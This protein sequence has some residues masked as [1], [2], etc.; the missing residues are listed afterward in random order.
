MSF[1]RSFFNILTR[2]IFVFLV[3]IIISIV[4][5]REL[6]PTMLGIWI[7]ISIL[8]QYLDYF[9]RFKFDVASINIIGE[10]RTNPSEVLFSNNLLTLLIAIIILPSFF[11]AYKFSFFSF[12]GLDEYKTAISFMII[13]ILI[14][15]LF[16]NY[17]YFL[18]AIQRSDIYANAISSQALLN[19]IF[20]V[21]FIY[22][23]NLGLEGIVFARLISCF[24]LLTYVFFFVHYQEDIR[25]FGQLPSWRYLKTLFFRS[26][27]FYFSGI[28][29]NILDTSFKALGSVLIS[30]QNLAFFSQAESFNKLIT[31]ASESLATIL[32]PTISNSQ[33]N[34]EKAKL[35]T[36]TTFKYLLIFQSFV[37]ALIYWIAEDIFI[38]MYGAEYLMS[39]G[40]FKQIALT[41]VI[42]TSATPFKVYLEG[43]G[44]SDLIPR[45][46]I[47]PVMIAFGVGYLATDLHNIEGLIFTFNLS[48]ISYALILTMAGIKFMQVKANLLVISAEDFK[49]L[50]S[51][52]SLVIRGLIKNNRNL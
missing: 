40:Y 17:K 37:L 20:I 49:L 2:D 36:I 10:G 23:Y 8:F 21:F 13:T 35:L 25:A 48:Y 34:L 28:L 19:L 44:R 29:V 43:I 1:L 46:A 7:A 30:K 32:Y 47:I 39:A 3:S 4:V 45:L 12:L 18:L 11:G 51:H 22:H 50:F 27:G 15:W 24:C 42:Y 16:S 41:Y 38:F 33:D 31:K 52:L 5:A 9:G 26:Q 14:E 6:G